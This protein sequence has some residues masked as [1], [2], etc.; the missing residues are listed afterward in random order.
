M[1]QIYLDNEQRK[2]LKSKELNELYKTRKATLLA[3]KENLQ[4][5]TVE[6][7]AEVAKAR[8]NFL[9]ETDGSGG[10]G[11]LVIKDIAI[12]KRN[13]YRKSGGE[14]QHLLSILPPKI[15][16]IDRELIAIDD[17]IKKEEANF[18][19]Y[20]NDRF[21]TQIE[22]QNNFIKSNPALQL[23]YYLLVTILQL[24]EL[25]A[26]GSYGKGN[27]NEQYQQ[28]KGT[29]RMVQFAGPSK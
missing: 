20:F 25:H 29:E 17:S 1:L 24:I 3:E 19:T 26:A 11:K 21:L 14:Y 9:S 8:E 10:T 7:Y 5:I 12:A 16:S 28:R 27:G 15:F 2:I 6:K 13:E 18:I 4:K 22:F 23:R